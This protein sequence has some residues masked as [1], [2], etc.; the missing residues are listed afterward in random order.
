MHSQALHLRR[1]DVVR[2]PARSIMQQYAE[3]DRQI[4][5]FPVA[6]RNDASLYSSQ[7]DFSTEVRAACCS[8]RVQ[9]LRLAKVIFLGDCAVGKTCLINR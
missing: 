3:C 7:T 1:P 2:S 6:Y 8:A 4:F 5:R 9:T